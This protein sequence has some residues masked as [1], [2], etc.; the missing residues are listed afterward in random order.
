MLDKTGE[1]VRISFHDLKLEFY[2]YS[3]KG[4]WREEISVAW[5]TMIMM[6]VITAYILQYPVAAF[7]FSCARSIVRVFRMGL[8][9]YVF[10]Y[11]FIFNVP[12]K[13]RLRNT[14]S[15]R[16]MNSVN[17][18]AVLSLNG[19]NSCVHNWGLVLSWR[20]ISPREGSHELKKI[21]FL[22]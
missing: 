16:T 14:L 15:W 3:K 13:H 20:N 17:S 11:H 1:E 5:I 9:T 18:R 2:I 21:W 12:W 8:F 4:N 6:G 22:S 10:I 7:F 19:S